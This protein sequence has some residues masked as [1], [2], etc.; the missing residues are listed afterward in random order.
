MFDNAYSY[1]KT[2][3]YNSLRQ[4]LQLLDSL[5]RAACH[6]PALDWSCI[7]KKYVRLLGPLLKV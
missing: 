1:W 3:S 2:G 6:M 7:Y 5:K 4:A